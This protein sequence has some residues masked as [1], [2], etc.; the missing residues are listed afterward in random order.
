MNTAGE[1]FVPTIAIKDAVSRRELEILA[2]VGIN[3]HGGKKHID[4]PYP[5]H[6]GK[7]DWRW[8][9]RNNRAFCTCVGTR[10]GEK[11]IAFDL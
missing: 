6:G 3:W 5:D 2:A 4:C 10:P 7:T 8:D 11:K 1:R 9:S